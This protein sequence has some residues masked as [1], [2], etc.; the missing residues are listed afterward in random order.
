[1]PRYGPARFIPLAEEAGLINEIGD[2]VLREAIAN[3]RRW[4]QRYGHVI[5]LSVNISPCQFKRRGPLSWLDQVVHAGLPRNS[6][7][8]EITEGVLVNDVDQVIRCLDALHAA[9]VK[10]SIDDFGTG[11]SSLAYLKLYDIDYLK[12]DKSFINNLTSDSSD[13]ALTEAIIDLAHRLGIQ[14]IAEGV[15]SGVQRDALAAI[16]ATTS[17]GH[18]YSQAVPYASFDDLLARQMVH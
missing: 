10:V 13:K 6:I 5:E 1:M 17:Q 9:G 2:W 11:F 14:A 16:G 12:I 15:E 4:H 7:T 3:A 18:Y 8:V